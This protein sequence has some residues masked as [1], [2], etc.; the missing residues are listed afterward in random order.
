MKRLQAV[1]LNKHQ[2]KKPLQ[3]QI[4][5]HNNQKMTL[6]IYL[7]MDQEII[8]EEMAKVKVRELE[9]EMDL[10]LVEEWVMEKADKL[11]EIQS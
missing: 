1:I 11:L 9:L 5:N 2:V 8:K 4:Q 3:S 7:V 6:V 10:I